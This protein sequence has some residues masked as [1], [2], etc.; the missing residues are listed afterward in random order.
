M[1][2]SQMARA[3][4]WRVTGVVAFALF[5]DYLIFGL[6]VPL[7]LYSPA[8]ISSESPCCAETVSSSP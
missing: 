1:S 8:Q 3:G 6:V 4:T 5:M 7:T 2:V